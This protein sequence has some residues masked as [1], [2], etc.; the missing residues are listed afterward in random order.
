MLKAIA[1]YLPSL[2]SEIAYDP[3][4]AMQA[5]VYSS[6][7]YCNYNDISSWTCGWACNEAPNFR[8]VELVYVGGTSLF[9]FAGYDTDSNK[10]VVSIRGTNGITDLK[11]IDSN[12]DITLL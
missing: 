10:I 12:I 11:N 2:F 8:D 6:A 9:S 1:M 5:A 3:N 4:L 7:A